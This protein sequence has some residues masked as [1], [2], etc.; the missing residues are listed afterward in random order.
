MGVYITNFHVQMDTLASCRIHI[1]ILV[2]EP[3]IR[4][5]SVIVCYG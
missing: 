1:V 2:T 5:I 4:H 3:I